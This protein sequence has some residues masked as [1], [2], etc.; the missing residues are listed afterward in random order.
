MADPLAPL[1]KGAGQPGDTV[2]FRVGACVVKVEVGGFDTFYASEVTV[3]NAINLLP[4]CQLLIPVGTAVGPRATGQEPVNSLALLSSKFKKFA[5]IRVTLIIQ[6]IDGTDADIGNAMTPGT[7]LMF[8]GYVAAT[9]IFM[10][11]KTSVNLSVRCAHVLTSVASGMPL[12]SP[13]VSAAGFTD[14]SV[15]YTNYSNDSV[16]PPGAFTPNPW[17]NFKVI[18]Q[19]FLTLFQSVEQKSWVEESGAD[20]SNPDIA[21]ILAA[22]DRSI[23]FLDQIIGLAELRYSGAGSNTMSSVLG[24]KL[25]QIL[26][27]TRASMNLFSAINQLCNAFD[28]RLVFTCSKGYVIPFDPLWSTDKLKFVRGGTAFTQ[29][30]IRNVGQN[31]SI[32]GYD[33]TGTVVQYTYNSGYRGPAENQENPGVKTYATWLLPVAVANHDEFMLIDAVDFPQWLT[34][35]TDVAAVAATPGAPAKDKVKPVTHHDSAVAATADANPTATTL[36]DAK[37]IA[38][39]YAYFNT[40]QKNFGPN[41]QVFTMAL[42]QDAVPGMCLGLDTLTPDGE[43]LTV[44][45]Y[46]I[47]TVCSVSAHTESASTEVTMS[48]VRNASEQAVIDDAKMDHFAWKDASDSVNALTLWD[49]K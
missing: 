28:L 23:G 18:A 44:Y 45:G 9:R 11:G 16:L 27:E 8:N 32:P 1:T 10:Q 33:I 12:F 26:M 19:A 22:T 42:R 29:D 41:N 17:T 38:V 7:Y 47:Q 4:S 43:R 36:A 46:V 2:R 13:V 48:H 20:K 3:T 31:Y 39:L 35:D 6:D 24:Q 5:T 30:T 49:T 37:A 15:V 25:M 40:L 34:L 14:F 21:R